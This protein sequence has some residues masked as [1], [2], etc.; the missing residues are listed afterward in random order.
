M[1]R[2]H[3]KSQDLIR[4]AATQPGA[5]GAAQ[6]H[7]RLGFFWGLGALDY[8]TLHGRVAV[9]LGARATLWG[10]DPAIWW[11]MVGPG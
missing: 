4:S 3:S 6:T 8:P 1:K 9:P 10:G 11:P 2:P 7:T 5:N